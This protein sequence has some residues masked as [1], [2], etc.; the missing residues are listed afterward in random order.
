MK[1]YSLDSVHSCGGQGDHE[2]MVETGAYNSPMM[3]KSAGTPTNESPCFDVGR[4][5]VT[6]TEE[7]KL[8]SGAH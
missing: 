7:P 8:R 1:F 2:H 6:R 4:I 3:L 5:T